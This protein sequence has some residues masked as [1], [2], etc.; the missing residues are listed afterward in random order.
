MTDRQAELRRFWGR[1]LTDIKER[2]AISPKRRAKAI[3]LAS[4]WDT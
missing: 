4:S 2:R 3:L 1:L